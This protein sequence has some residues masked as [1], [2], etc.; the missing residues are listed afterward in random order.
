MFALFRIAEERQQRGQK[1]SAR[2]PKHTE[3]LFAVVFFL[4]LG[5]VLW[6]TGHRPSGGE[7]AFVVFLLSVL[8]ILDEIED[9]RERLDRIEKATGKVENHR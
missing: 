5:V 9:I 3:F 1:M 4:I 6:L 2:R 8:Y 7:V